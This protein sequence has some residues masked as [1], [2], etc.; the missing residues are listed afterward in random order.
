MIETRGIVRK[1]PQRKSYNGMIT[2]ELRFIALIAFTV[3]TLYA[4]YD[5]QRT[6]TLSFQI[7]KVSCRTTK[8]RGPPETIWS[9]KSPVFHFDLMPTLSTQCLYVHVG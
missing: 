8:A 3:I 7:K 5:T 2:V 9:K 6:N 4:I 1:Q